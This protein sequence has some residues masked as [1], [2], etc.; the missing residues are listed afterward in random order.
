MP[1]TTEHQQRIILGAVYFAPGDAVLSRK[2]RDTLEA[3]HGVSLSM[4]S[5]RGELLRL[6]DVGAV[7]VKGDMVRLTEY[8]N[9]AFFS[10]IKLPGWL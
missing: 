7:D 6:Q 2:L 4:D 8:G 5:L 9:D 10:R 3:M 1:G